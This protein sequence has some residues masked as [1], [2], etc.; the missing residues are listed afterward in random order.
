MNTKKR[1]NTS[2]HIEFKVIIKAQ[3]LYNR[4]LCG[5]LATWRMR[6]KNLISGQFERILFLA[7]E[8]EDVFRAGCGTLFLV[9]LASGV[10]FTKKSTKIVIRVSASRRHFICSKNS[11]PTLISYIRFKSLVGRTLSQIRT[12]ARS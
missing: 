1:G 12:S 9:P 10:G 11:L 4:Y 8:G 2:R 3:C 7:Y 5:L 6:D